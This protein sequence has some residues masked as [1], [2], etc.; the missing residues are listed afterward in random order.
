MAPG[1]VY[2]CDR[3]TCTDGGCRSP[4]RVSRST[5]YNHRKHEKSRRM[6]TPIVGR[7]PDNDGGGFSASAGAG[8]GA[9]AGA[10]AGA[11]AG[12]GAGEGAGAGAGAGAGTCAGAS[13]NDNAEAAAGA[14]ARTLDSRPAR[15]GRRCDADETP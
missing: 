1:W 15:I 14:R 2:H 13:S 7:A 12:A 9:R 4:E 5:L 11:V 6:D 3:F 8:A 10:G